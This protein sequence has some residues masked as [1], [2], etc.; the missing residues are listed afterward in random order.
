M[1][2]CCPVLKDKENQGLFPR[3]NTAIACPLEAEI[4]G[5]P[6]IPVRSPNQT[7]VI[8]TK[9]SS[10]SHYSVR[11]PEPLC[12]LTSHHLH[13]HALGVLPP[14]YVFQGSPSFHLYCLSSSPA[15]IFGH[16]EYAIASS[17]ISLLSPVAEKRIENSPYKSLSFA[18][19]PRPAFPFSSR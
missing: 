18:S 4:Q 8:Y 12:L 13:Q 7:E 11:D 16:L 14:K 6:Y 9:G 10:Q 19:L 2:V 1:C 15:T 3:Y 5:L 17:L